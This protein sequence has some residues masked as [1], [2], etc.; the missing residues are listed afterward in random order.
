MA[1]RLFAVKRLPLF[2]LTALLVAVPC[3]RVT[4]APTPSVVAFPIGNNRANYSWWHRLSDAQKG[5][6]VQG[7]IGA[8]Q[9]GYTGGLLMGL[10]PSMSANTAHASK[11]PQYPKL[12][13]SKSVKFYIAQVDGFYSRI[14][15]NKNALL[16]ASVPQ[17]LACASDVP[18]PTPEMCQGFES[19][20]SNPK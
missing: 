8:L 2:A 10:V 6:A 20:F 12:E 17:I 9:Y 18:F 16:V 19:M 4:A 1:C 3:V 14:K 15:N 7:M 5:I 13:F 11:P